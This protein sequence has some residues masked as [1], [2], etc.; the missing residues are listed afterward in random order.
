MKGV[1]WIRV[2]EFGIYKYWESL[3]DEESWKEAEEKS[4][5]TLSFQPFF[6]KKE[7]TKKSMLP[8][9]MILKKCSHP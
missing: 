7:T 4:Y 9:G 1:C 5:E 2:E 6:R 8:N 3:S